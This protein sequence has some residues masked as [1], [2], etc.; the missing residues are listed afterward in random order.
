MAQLTTRAGKGSPLT[1]AEVD[2]NFNNLNNDKVEKNG[3][4]LLTGKLQL[5]AGDASKASIK[6]TQGSANP[7]TPESGDL[8]NNG[9]V[10]KY[11][12]GS[13]TANLITSLDGQSFAG[14]V[15]IGDALTVTGNLIVNGPTTTI[16][17]TT[18]VN[19]QCNTVTLNTT[20]APTDAN[21]TNGG[22]VIKGT[23]DKTFKWFSDGTPGFRSSENIEI[24]AGKV[25]RIGSST[26][27]TGT[28]LGTSVINSSLTAVGTIT[29]GTWQGS[30]VAVAHGGTGAGTAA[31]ARTNLGLGT[32]SNIRF[33]NLG[34]GVDAAA[35]EG[36]I[37]RMDAANVILSD[38]LKFS[39]VTKGI[40]SANDTLVAIVK[41]SGVRFTGIGIGVDP[42]A[43]ELKIGN[44]VTATS[45]GALTVASVTASTG[46]A[47]LTAGNL[48]LTAGEIV[49]STASGKGLKDAQGDLN[50]EML[51]A[52]IKI[53]SLGVGSSAPSGT[54]GEI[55]ASNEITAYY[56]SDIRLK[57][58]ISVIT[59][60]LTKV[61]QI[62]G[63]EFDWKQ[64][65]IEERGGEDGYFVR[66]HDV[67]V[68]AQEIEAIL[69]EVVASRDDGYKA[70]RY[71]KMI[72]LLIQ[73]IKELNQQVK[74]LKTNAQ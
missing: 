10:L 9:G 63:V 56:S 2:A 17:S 44:T 71:E 55:R 52:G 70:V 42:V 48:V 36:V 19:V 38:T 18:A 67:G 72:P 27:L 23:T 39:D 57:E 54:A 66:K 73:A 35:G 62:N 15:E 43:N 24:A 46:N 53:T 51:N 58:N 14:D 21:A 61:E 22:I 7:S 68:I 32:G 30:V 3:S 69:P 59:D 45:A 41:N 16:N 50:L 34:L 8:W 40:A 74:Q 47:T 5:V 49:F 20:G 13:L 25:F 26:V 11:Y 64:T 28:T 33:N 12:N 37:G 65:H 31:D 4:T 60:A 29:S 6:I 1:N